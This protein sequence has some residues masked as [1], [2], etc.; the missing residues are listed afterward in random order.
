MWHHTLRR[1]ARGDSAIEVLHMIV[2]GEPPDDAEIVGNLF[3][4]KPHRFV[5]CRIAVLTTAKQRQRHQ[6]RENPRYSSGQSAH[7]HSPLPGRAEF[8]L[9]LLLPR[10]LP[11]PARPLPAYRKASKG[12]IG[13]APAPP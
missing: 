5:A 2:E 4:R 8:V 10:A 6:R 12:K 11:Y 3:D 9:R 7:H 13:P 1:S